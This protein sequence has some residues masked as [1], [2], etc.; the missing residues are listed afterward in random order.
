[1]TLSAV[2]QRFRFVLLA[3]CLVAWVCALGVAFWSMPHETAGGMRFG[4]LFVLTSLTVLMQVA[5]GAGGKNR[6]LITLGVVTLYSLY[7]ERG[8]LVRGASVMRWAE[9]VYGVA[10]A[11]VLCELVMRVATRRDGPAEP[12]PPEE[13]PP[14]APMRGLL[15]VL[16]RM[17]GI[18]LVA[19]VMTLIAAFT[20]THIPAQYLPHISPQDNV[21]HFTG[22]LMLTSVFVLTQAACGVR[23]PRRTLM[24]LLTMAV[25][26]AVDES[27]QSYVNRM[28]HTADWLADMHGAVAATVLWELVILMFSDRNPACF[29]N[30]GGGC[31]DR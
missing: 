10:L 3:M 12:R 1:M 29:P 5:F 19:C 21:L 2:P 9:Y 26:A 4:T 23:Q 6:V 25:Y 11:V 8:G 17:R 28:P 24:T 14:P 22:F 16:R 18:L 13:P 20:A 27:T 15:R 31:P 30:D 7:W